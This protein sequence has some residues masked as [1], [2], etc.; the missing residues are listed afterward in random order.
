MNEKIRKQILAIRDSGKTNM[1]DSYRVQKLAYES[2]FYE[3]VLHIE[4][5]RK[6][7]CQFILTGTLPSDNEK[8]SR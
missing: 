2:E 1:F 4:E 7:Y 3:L 6:A 5:N 8:M